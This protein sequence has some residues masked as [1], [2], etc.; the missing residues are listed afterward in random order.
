MK[1]GKLSF[2]VMRP[3][4]PQRTACCLGYAPAAISQTPGG[5]RRHQTSG[6]DGSDSDAMRHVIHLLGSS[7]ASNSIKPRDIER[8][9]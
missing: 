4:D 6:G 3:T 8:E 2:Y 5:G 1:N 7:Y 9:K